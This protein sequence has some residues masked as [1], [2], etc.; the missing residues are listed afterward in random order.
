MSNVSQQPVLFPVLGQSAE[1]HLE[2][3]HSGLDE[4]GSEG[5]SESLVSVAAAPS[6]GA[7]LLP[8][9][10]RA[11]LESTVT[12][13]ECWVLPPSIHLQRIRAIVTMTAKDRNQVTASPWVS[14]PAGQ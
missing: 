2:L 6:E 8:G 3:E 10:S 9:A 1:L 7:R 13:D 14:V 5:P 11:L 12:T 4:E